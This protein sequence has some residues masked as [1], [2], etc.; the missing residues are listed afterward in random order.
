MSVSTNVE[1]ELCRLLASYKGR[2]R[3]R[4]NVDDIGECA[5]SRGARKIATRARPMEHLYEDRPV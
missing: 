2:I 1:Q 4:R 5:H 3:E